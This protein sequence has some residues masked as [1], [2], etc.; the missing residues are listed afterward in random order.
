M[1]GAAATEE[2]PPPEPPEPRAGPEEEEEED[3]VWTSGLDALWAGWEDPSPENA[4]VLFFSA[5]AA[6]SLG[7]LAVRLLFVLAAIIW[8]S[9]K[10]C[11]I[12]ALLVFVAVFFA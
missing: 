12:A 11:A 8:T 4:L 9:I 6:L 7:L 2:P 3:G 10:Y 5:A 1:P